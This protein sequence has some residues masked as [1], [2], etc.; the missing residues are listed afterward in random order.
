M[1]NHP[2]VTGKLAAAA[3]SPAPANIQIAGALMIM[4]PSLAA[5]SA[6]LLVAMAVAPVPVTS[7]HPGLFVNKAVQEHQHV[8][9]QCHGVRRLATSARH[10]Q[11]LMT[12]QLEDVLSSRGEVLCQVS[13][14]RPRPMST[15]T[16]E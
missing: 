5:L 12:S 16:C 2:K 7:L 3:T 14:H 15:L 10:L 4:T 6:A 8:G 9:S 13:D 11:N 1:S